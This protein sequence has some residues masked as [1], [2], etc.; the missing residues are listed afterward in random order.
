MATPESEYAGVDGL[1][2]PP[3]H[4]PVASERLMLLYQTAAEDPTSG[5]EIVGLIGQ[6]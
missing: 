3:P 6:A 1:V 2:Q 4:V 5:E